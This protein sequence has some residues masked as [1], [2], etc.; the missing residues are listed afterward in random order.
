MRTV[1]EI[2]RQEV[3]HLDDPQ[4]GH[5]ACAHIPLKGYKVN[6]HKSHSLIAVE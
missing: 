5:N 1:A 6:F 4:T 3:P 2:G